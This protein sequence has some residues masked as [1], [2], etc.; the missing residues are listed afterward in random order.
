ML[1]AWRVPGSAR[2][3]VVTAL[4]ATIRATAQTAA[5]Y[6]RIDDQG[7][8]AWRARATTTALLIPAFAERYPQ[9]VQLQPSSD[10]RWQQEPRVALG[11]VVKILARGMDPT[12]GAVR[13]RRTNTGPSSPS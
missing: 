4:Y 2:A 1:D 6:Q 9:T 12:T 8:R 7:I 11:E 5:A 10:H 3:P 13:R